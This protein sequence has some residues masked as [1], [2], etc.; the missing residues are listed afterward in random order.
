MK[1]KIHQIPQSPDIL[2][3]ITKK[4][5]NLFYGSMPVVAIFY[6]SFFFLEEFRCHIFLDTLYRDWIMLG[7]SLLKK[8]HSSSFCKGRADIEALKVVLQANCMYSR[9][10][11]AGT[12]NETAGMWFHSYLLI[13]DVI[14]K[15]SLFFQTNYLLESFFTNLNQ[16]HN[17]FDLLYFDVHTRWISFFF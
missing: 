6:W 11:M 7:N 10:L 8:I 13:K 5:Y 1:R 16:H 15:I 17:R 4:R 12:K 14:W 2:S 3:S 9:F